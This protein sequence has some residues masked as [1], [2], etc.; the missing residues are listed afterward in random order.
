MT[1]KK[2]WDME[3]ILAEKKI[4]GRGRYYGRKEV[5]GGGKPYSRKKLWDKENIIAEKNHRKRK[6]LWKKRNYGTW[7]TLQKK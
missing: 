6:I 7:K 5:M 4:I 1:R 2:L 3:N